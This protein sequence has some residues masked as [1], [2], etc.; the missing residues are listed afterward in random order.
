MPDLLTALLD[1]MS[2]LDA[3]DLSARAGRRPRF[4]RG[5][6]LV[7]SPAFPNELSLEELN[8]ATEALAEG[9]RQG[10]IKI[11]TSVEHKGQRYRVGYTS[12]GGAGSLSV[13]P[14]L[15]RRR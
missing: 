9:P 12:D 11:G 8:K 2:R 4:F 7:Y 5:L 3:S 6:A 10:W 13:Q 15:D 14:A 1:E